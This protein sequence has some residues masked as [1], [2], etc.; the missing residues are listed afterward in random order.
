MHSENITKV[1]YPNDEVL[2]GKTLRLQQQFFFVDLLAAG[3]DPRPPAAETAARQVPREMGRPAQR[4]PPG[5]RRGRADAPAGGRAPAGL[6]HG[7]ERHAQHLR[8]HQPHPAARGAGEM[9]RR[10]VRPA[11]AAPPGDHL[12]DQP[13]LPRRGPRPA[14]RATTP[15]WRGCRSSTR[16][17][18]ATCAW[19]IWPPSAATASTA[20]R[21]CTPTCSSR[22]CMRDFAELWPEKFC[23][24]TNG[25]TPRRFVAVSNPPLA[26]LITEPHRR[27]LAA[28]PRPAPQAGAAGRRRGVPAAVARGEAHRQARPRRAHRAAHRRRR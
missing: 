11:A 22:P 14:S 26:Q 27:R 4:H 1:L 17:A 25:V 8:L 23:N 12:R 15:A 6:G 18:S 3:H 16:A 10:P 5:H 28:R 21:G 9:A 13:P 7:L 2:Q 20:S 19:P 24:V